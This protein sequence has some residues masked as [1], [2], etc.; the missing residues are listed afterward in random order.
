EVQPA[1]PAT[2]PDA[3]A[4]ALRIL[5]VDDNVDAAETLSALL[6]LSGHAAL[7][8]NDGSEALRMVQQLPP[9]LVFLDIGMPR[10]NGYEVARAI[11]EELKLDDI[12]LV[13]LTGW[14][15][16]DDRAR[17]KAAG[18]DRHMTKPVTIGAIEAFLANPAEWK[19]RA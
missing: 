11:R 13:A 5:V 14:G 7:V 2:P 6:E 3:G 12:V 19:A 4:G 10:M 8:A 15:G 18:F 1:A 17:T 16:A 9:H